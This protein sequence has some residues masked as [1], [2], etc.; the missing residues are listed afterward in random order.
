MATTTQSKQSEKPPVRP[1]HEIRLGRIRAAIWENETTEGTRFNV[2]LSRLYKDGD[3]W[4]D[5]SSFGRDDLLLVAKI[6]D[7]CHTWIFSKS[8][9]H[10]ESSE[11]SDGNTPF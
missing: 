5:S 8:G 10:G 4:K 7:Q 11:E 6:V 3:N 9:S 2:T 1:V